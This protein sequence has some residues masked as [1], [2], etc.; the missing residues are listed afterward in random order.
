MLLELQEAECNQKIAITNLKKCF[1]IKQEI[2]NKAKSEMIEQYNQKITACIQKK[3]NYDVII[4]ACENEIEQC[5][6][7]MQNK[8]NSLF[9]DKSGQ[10]SLKEE[11]VLKKWIHKIKNK[12]TGA[13][14]FNTYVVEPMSVELEMMENKL[15]DVVNHIKQDTIRFVA[16]MKQAKEENN[17]MFENTMNQ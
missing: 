12:F 13:K 7:Q 1:D 15:P 14:K 10:I 4:E 8:M 11:N 17:K 3:T 9:S 6:S 2:L 5:K 16:K